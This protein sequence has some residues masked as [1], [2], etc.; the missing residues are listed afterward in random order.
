MERVKAYIIAYIKRFC[1]MIYLIIVIAHI[2][3]NRKTHQAFWVKSFW[4]I[5]MAVIQRFPFYDYVL[6]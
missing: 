2:Q 6:M 4:V 3:S 5:K 1:R